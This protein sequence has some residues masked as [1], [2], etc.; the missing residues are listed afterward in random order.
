MFLE[1]PDGRIH[2]YDMELLKDLLE[3][4]DG[5]IERLTA[6]V[7][8]YIDADSWGLYDSTEYIIGL[9][10]VACQGYLAATYSDLKVEKAAALRGEP[11]HSSGLTY[12]E[13]INHAANAWK[14]HHEWSLPSNKGRGHACEAL[15]KLLVDDNADPLTSILGAVVFARSNRLQALLLHLSAWR[16][17]LARKPALPV[18]RSES[19]CVSQGPSVP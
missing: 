3:L 14:H 9:G 16:D 10:F 1:L 15:D 6:N 13:I 8:H 19:S 5:H 7:P 18:T 12:V 17:A 2:D 11:R 4:L